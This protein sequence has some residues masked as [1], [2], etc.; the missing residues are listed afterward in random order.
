MEDVTTALVGSRVQVTADGETHTGRV[1]AVNYTPKFGNP[2]L[3]VLLDDP[4]ADGRDE[5]VRPPDAVSR[6]D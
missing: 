4:L 6:L 1:S 5:V 3:A 2:V